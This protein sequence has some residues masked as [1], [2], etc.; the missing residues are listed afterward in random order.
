MTRPLSHLRVTRD[1]G[2]AKCAINPSNHYSYALYR[3]SFVRQVTAAGKMCAPSAWRRPRLGG[4]RPALIGSASPSPRERPMASRPRQDRAAMS[5]NPMV[6]RTV[7]ALRRAL[8]GL[9]ARKAT[10][11]LVP[12]M[13]ALHDGHVSLIRLAKRA[14]G[15]GRGLDL[16]QPHPVCADGRF[17]FLP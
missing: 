3:E 2:Q 8:D 13:G 12:T 1:R 17:W 5:R 6:A 11:A 9:R 16:C 7:P 14:G 15:K 10:V 4:C